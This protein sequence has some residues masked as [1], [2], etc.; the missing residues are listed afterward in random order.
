MTVVPKRQSKPSAKPGT[1]A[2]AVTKKKAERKPYPGL[3]DD[4]G[5]PIKLTAVPT[6]FDSKK[7][8]PLKRSDFKTEDIF[9][10]MKADAAEAMAK[11]LRA[12]A[13]DVRNGGGSK[14]TRA[15]VKRLKLIQERVAKME[16]ELRDAD[17]DI[18]GV[19]A[20]LSASADDSESEAA[21]SDK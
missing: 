2:E 14:K 6:D 15:K 3:T 5:E 4:K 1:K 16:K 11:K 19:L 20:E 12:E 7:H 18:D 21:T 8:K 13:E 9:L 10:D 17:V